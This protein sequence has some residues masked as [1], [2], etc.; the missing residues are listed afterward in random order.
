MN[1]KMVDFI[2]W[3]RHSG[4]YGFTKFFV[5]L[6]KLRFPDWHLTLLSR[7][8][9]LDANCHLHPHV[10]ANFGEKRTDGRMQVLNPAGQLLGPSRV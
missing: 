8:S 5:L 3:W 7:G 9:P 6:I 10:R 1:N 2:E 4:Y